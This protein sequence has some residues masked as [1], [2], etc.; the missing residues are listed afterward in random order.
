MNEPCFGLYRGVVTDVDDPDK[1]MR[2]KVRIPEILGEQ[3]TGWVLPCVSPGMRLIPGKDTIVWVAFEAGDVSR[4][5]W[6]GTLGDYKDTT[7]L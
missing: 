4:P 5:V 1:M 6:I 3:R 2:I 7:D